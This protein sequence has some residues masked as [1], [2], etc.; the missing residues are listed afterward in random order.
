MTTRN[1]KSRS[2]PNRRR[3]I[4]SFVGFTRVFETFL[5]VFQR[6]TPSSS[7]RGPVSTRG[8]GDGEERTVSLLWITEGYELNLTVRTRSSI[9]ALSTT[10][11]KALRSRLKR[12]LIEPLTK[13]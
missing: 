10:E 7:S 4:Q 2:L 5:K 8:L 9:S 13:L 11:R 3:A 12:D 1:S 6:D